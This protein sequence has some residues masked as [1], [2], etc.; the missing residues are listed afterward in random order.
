M[1][2]ASVMGACGSAGLQLYSYGRT[3]SIP[4]FT[5]AWRPTSFYPK[6]KYNYDGGMHTLCL[7][8]IKVREEDFVLLAKTGKTS[9]LPPRYMTVN[10]ALEQL[11]ESEDIEKGGVVTMDDTLVVGMARLGHVDQVIRAGSVRELMEVDFGAPLHCLV[12]AAKETTELEVEA[13]KPYFVE[14]STM[15]TRKWAAF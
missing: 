1:H 15:L 12:V 4:F 7:L 14:G 10:Q 2:N 11:I 13:M 3:V 6:M 9:Y 5:D 8:D